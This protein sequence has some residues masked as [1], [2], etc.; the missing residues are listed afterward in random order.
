MKSD[1]WRER[2]RLIIEAYLAGDFR[3]FH[4]LAEY[5]TEVEAAR[6][7]LR[8]MGFGVQGTPIL[9]QVQEVPYAS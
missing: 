5:L 7:A 6:Q 4:L 2:L 3:S 1:V 9:R 8:D